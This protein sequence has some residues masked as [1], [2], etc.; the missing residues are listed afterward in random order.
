MQAGPDDLVL[1]RETFDKGLNQVV[2]EFEAQY[3][4]EWRMSLSGRKRP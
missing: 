1:N 4:P 3:P 2:K